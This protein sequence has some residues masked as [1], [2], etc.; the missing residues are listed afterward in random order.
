MCTRPPATFIARTCVASTQMIGAKVSISIEANLITNHIRWWPMIRLAQIDNNL[1]AIS[2]NAEASECM[3]Y[4][5]P[6]RMRNVNYNMTATATTT[7]TTKSLPHNREHALRLLGMLRK[8]SHQRTKLNGFNV[9][10][11]R[12]QSTE[13]EARGMNA[14][15]GS[16]VIIKIYRRENAP[17]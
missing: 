4:S 9:E 12:R 13:W 8:L 2:S 10:V 7:P 15:I 3:K 11:Q 16:D 17:Q 14:A 1:I 5:R 6:A